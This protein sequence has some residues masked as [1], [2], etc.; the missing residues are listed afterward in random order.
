MTFFECM[1]MFVYDSN[2]LWR[3]FCLIYTFTICDPQNFNFECHQIPRL[4]TIYLN[5]MTPGGL[6]LHVSDSNTRK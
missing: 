5:V 2:D 1:F 3:M 4:H 6:H